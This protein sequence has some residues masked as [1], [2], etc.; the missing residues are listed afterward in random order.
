[1]WIW[2]IIYPPLKGWWWSV[3]W[4]RHA[5]AFKS[6]FSGTNSSG[7]I[8]P[9]CRVDMWTSVIRSW[10]SD[11]SFYHQ[12]SFYCRHATA[13]NEGWQI[14]LHF[15]ACCCCLRVSVSP[16]DEH[17]VRPTSRFL[18]LFFLFSSFPYSR[19]LSLKKSDPLAGYI[20]WFPLSPFYQFYL[21]YSLVFVFFFLII[22]ITSLWTCIL[23][24]WLRAPRSAFVQMSS[25]HVHLVRLCLPWISFLFLSPFPFS[26]N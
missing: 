7:G 18:S 10:N 4:C 2:Y 3:F 21:N 26:L 12:H 22:I 6:A 9:A 14:G 23:S 25:C 17:R 20:D 8:H 15:L 13:C 1:M 16:R 24:H 11:Y 19:I 5:T